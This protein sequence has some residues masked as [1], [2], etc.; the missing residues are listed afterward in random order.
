[1]KRH[2]M[3]S[4]VML[5]FVSHPLSYYKLCISRR[6]TFHKST[7]DSQEV[8]CTIWIMFYPHE[9]TSSISVV[10]ALRFTFTYS[11]IHFFF[12]LSVGYSLRQKCKGSDFQFFTSGG[13]FGVWLGSHCSND[14]SSPWFLCHRMTSVGSSHSFRC[15]KVVMWPQPSL[16]SI[17]VKDQN[18]LNLIVT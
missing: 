17:R 12:F 11:L 1:M 9:I 10:T 2:I 13:L 16:K 4:K 15:F 5:A 7:L 3:I 6:Q 14:I 18:L 8:S